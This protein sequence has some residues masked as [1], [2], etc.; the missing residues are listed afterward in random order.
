MTNF[1][2]HAAAYRTARNVFAEELAA[3]AALYAQLE[4]LEHATNE[5]IRLHAATAIGVPEGTI[6]HELTLGPPPGA[7]APAPTGRQGRVFKLGAGWASVRLLKK[8]GTLAKTL[9]TFFNWEVS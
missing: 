5:A 1:T 6:V 3:V 2:K 9:T 8:D 7:V 4:R